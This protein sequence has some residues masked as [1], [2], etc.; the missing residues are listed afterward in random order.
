M[1]EEGLRPGQFEP[2]QEYGWEILCDQEVIYKEFP[3][4]DF[5]VALSFMMQ[6]VLHAKRRAVIIWI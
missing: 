6:V 2:L 3:F 1:E 4:Q 5:S